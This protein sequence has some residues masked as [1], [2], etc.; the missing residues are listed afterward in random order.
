MSTL[1]AQTAREDARVRYNVFMFLVFG[2]VA[3]LG[4]RLV[5]MQIVDRDE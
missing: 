4:A 3:F 1:L 5:Q 2:L